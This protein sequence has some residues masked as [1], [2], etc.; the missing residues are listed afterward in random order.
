MTT[1][2]HPRPAMRLPRKARLILWGKAKSGKTLTALKIARGLVGP[3]GTLCVIDT[4]YE[5]STIYADR[6]TFDLVPMDPPFEPT[7]MAAVVRSIAPHYDA[8]IVDSATLEWTG[9]GGS[10]EL[11]D[12]EKLKLGDNAWAAWSKVTPMHNRFVAALVRCPAHVICTLRAKTVYEPV[13]NPRTG[14]YE[15]QE[16]GLAPVQREEFPYELDWVARLEP[17]EAAVKLTVTGA[18]YDGWQ[19]RTVVNPDVALGVE[20]AAWL[21][22]GVAPAV[23]RPDEPPSERTTT[24]TD[25]EVQVPM[26]DD[27][28]PPSPPPERPPQTTPG[29]MTRG[30]RLNAIT[31]ALFRQVPDR[32]ETGRQQRLAL[33]EACFGKPT[34]REVTTLADDILAAGFHRLL[35]KGG[36]EREPGEEG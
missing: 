14:T 22:Q 32:G 5:A 3:H 2:I 7:R 34:M 35:A 31:Q 8:V 29:A 25:R 12:R 10:L 26:P 1:T 13:K 23:V 28:P 4:E 15:P 20:L 16:I 30:Q 21:N 9:E 33:L 19:G 24:A 17:E 27:G 36:R 6:E 18:R 11:I